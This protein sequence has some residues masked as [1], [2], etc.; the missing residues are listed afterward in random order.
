MFQLSFILC[1]QNE[2]LIRFFY[3]NYLI[4]VVWFLCYFY[5]IFKCYDLRIF[6]ILFI[7]DFEPFDAMTTRSK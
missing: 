7:A 6:V 5:A 4:V 3:D 2:I 1:K